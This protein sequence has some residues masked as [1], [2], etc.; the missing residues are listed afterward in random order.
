LASELLAKIGKFVLLPHL[1]PSP[2]AGEAFDLVYGISVLTH[3]NEEMQFSW[4]S[5]LSRITRPGG[6]LL[7]TVHGRNHHAQLPKEAQRALADK[8]FHFH[9]ESTLTEGLPDFYRTAYHTPDYIQREWSRFFEI[10]ELRERGLSD[11]QDLILCRR[12]KI[13]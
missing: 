12:P 4:L 5:E 10:V 9:A 13:P 1:P 6:F 2:F 3:L 7:L 8:G 11:W